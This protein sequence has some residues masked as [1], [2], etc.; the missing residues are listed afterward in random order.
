[1]NTIE[2]IYDKARQ[3]AKPSNYFQGRKLPEDLVLPDNILIFPNPR[4][5]FSTAVSHARYSLILPVVDM[6]YY[7]DNLR[8]DLSPG[9]ILLIFP[10]QYRCYQSTHVEFD[11]LF[12]TFELPSL[13]SYL[14]KGPMMKMTD[15]AW[16]YVDA[17]IENYSSEDT[18]G[19]AL[20]LTDL[21][22]ELAQNPVVHRTRQMPPLILQA[23][24]L[25]NQDLSQELDNK[26]I[27]EKLGISESNL[28]LVFRRE[29]GSSIGAYTSNLRLNAA[30]SRLENTTMSIEEIAYSCGYDSIYA[31]SHFF[32]NKAGISPLK[33][34]Q[35]KK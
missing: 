32:K 4:K 21:L 11:R 33:Y 18:L 20:L 34:R 27:A 16:Q 2:S 30:K 12:I 28:R 6:V 19:G 26:T 17:M 15:R 14:P 9:N 7:V 24:S 8:I 25:I 5:T 31:F 3:I 13:Q 23:I 29:M 10:H 35:S 22:R 1:M